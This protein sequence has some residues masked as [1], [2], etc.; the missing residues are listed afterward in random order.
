M[1]R[2]ALVLAVL[3][4]ALC[5]CGERVT[6][7]ETTE[8][9]TTETASEAMTTTKAVKPTGDSAILH[10]TIGNWWGLSSPGSE[11]S[12]QPD[13]EVRAEDIITVEEDFI[14]KIGCTIK[15][16]AVWPDGVRAHVKTN[17]LVY[18]PVSGLMISEW[19]ETF[20]F[21][22]EYKLGTTYMD[23]GSTICFSFS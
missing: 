6:E 17:G 18:A 8:R 21:E 2:I 13:R 23:A 9:I 20:N 3:V 7:S 10:V 4:V 16:I 11:S 14:E 15:I 19:S 1:K 5:G 12:V 22:Q